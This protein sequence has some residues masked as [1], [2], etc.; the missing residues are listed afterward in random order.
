MVRIGRIA[1]PLFLASRMSTMNTDRPSVRFLAW[2][3]GVVRAS[4]IIR[5]EYSRAAGPDL[6][7]VDDVA[8][9]A[10]AL[11]K[12]LQRR[13]IGAAGRLGDA[14]RLQ[15][16][17]AAGDL[18]QPF[19]LL[20]VA[21][22]P[23]QRAHGVHLGVA[24]AA[25][26]AG[27]LDLLQD[28]GGGGK[29]QAG[30]AIFFRNQHREIAGLGQRIDEGAR[31]GHLAV[32]LAPVFAGK[33]R[34]QFG[35]ASRIS[36]K[37]PFASIVIAIIVAH[38]ARVGETTEGTACCMALIAFRCRNAWSM[39]SRRRKRSSPRSPRLALSASMC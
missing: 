2:S 36:A 12:G 25:V 38:S 5:S 21:A 1:S 13:G 29:L 28:R 27:A 33:L 35:T 6:L 22:V 3:F 23:Q 26:A 18:R 24:S 14:E 9:I 11:R 4:R 19:G 31:I 16:Q 17:F 10:V 32:E 39:A 15:P 7:A 30:A 8:V 20:L 37:G 34:A